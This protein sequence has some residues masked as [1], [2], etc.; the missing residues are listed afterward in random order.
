MNSLGEMAR[1][2]AERL[3]REH[4][5]EIQTFSLDSVEI[6]PGPDGDEA[7]VEATIV[8]YPDDRTMMRLVAS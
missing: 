4:G 8:V 1:D 2:I 7:I 5:C 6:V 3:A